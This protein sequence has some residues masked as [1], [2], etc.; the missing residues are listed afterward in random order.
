LDSIT[1]G[2]DD[3]CGGGDSKFDRCV[4]VYTVQMQ[5]TSYERIFKTG[6]RHDI[7]ISSG[8]KMNSASNGL[9]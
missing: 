1:V 5:T 9:F 8:T 7:K 3:R 2:I 6:R 4:Y